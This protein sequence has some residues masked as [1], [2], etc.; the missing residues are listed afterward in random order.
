[1]AAHSTGSPRSACSVKAMA[2]PGSNKIP[3]PRTKR[4]TSLSGSST[5]MRS[6]LSNCLVM[7]RA[8]TLF[9]SA[10]RHPA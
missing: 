7:A 4:P 10:L 1:M 3:S 6:E 5:G 8:S 2:S 9:A